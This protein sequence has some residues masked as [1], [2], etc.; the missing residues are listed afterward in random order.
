M[1]LVLDMMAMLKPNALLSG[2][3]SLRL[4]AWLH[5]GDELEV[6]PKYTNAAFVPPMTTVPELTATLEPKSPLSIRP[7]AVRVSL[8]ASPHVE[9][10]E[11]VHPKNKNTVCTSEP[12]TRVPALR[13]V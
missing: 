3:L 13:A 10:D 1:V 9:D 12:T 8:F 2:P 4:F 11:E 5:V 7:V 6:H